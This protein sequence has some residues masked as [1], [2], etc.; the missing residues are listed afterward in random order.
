MTPTLRLTISGLSRRSILLSG[1]EA[2]ILPPVRPGTMEFI[3]W[4]RSLK[5]T[6][7]RIS[8]AAKDISNTYDGFEAS[9]TNPMRRSFF[10]RHRR[11][12]RLRRGLKGRQYGWKKIGDLSKLTLLIQTLHDGVLDGSQY[13]C[14]VLTGKS[15]Y[16]QGTQRSTL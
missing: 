4:A 12:G 7:G 14:P 16:D 3:K 10:G 5:P 2:D 9:E 11:T 8:L 15:S 6:L 13:F 1:S